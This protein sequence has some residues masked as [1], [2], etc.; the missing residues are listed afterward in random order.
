MNI[1][2][3][4]IVGGIIGWLAGVI[5]GT[6]TGILMNIII[7]IVGS[8]LGSWLFGS[9]LKI[10]AANNAGNFNIPG[11]LFGVLGAV[12]LIFLARLIF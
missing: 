11:L 3:S 1:I 12:V 9:V 5:M 8:A 10:G 7:G 2:I 4:I 6:N